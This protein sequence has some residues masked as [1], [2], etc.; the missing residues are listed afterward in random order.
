MKKPELSTIEKLEMVTI[1]DKILEV[2]IDD[3]WGN[4]AEE[5]LSGTYTIPY[6]HEG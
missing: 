3:V 4:N 1:L 2:G 6:V 5:S